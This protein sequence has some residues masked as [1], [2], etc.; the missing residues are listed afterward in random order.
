[1]V[2]IGTRNIKHKEKMC[3]FATITLT[4]VTRSP[5]EKKIEEESGTVRENKREGDTSWVCLQ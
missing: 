1:M 2:A 3:V 5:G 4:E